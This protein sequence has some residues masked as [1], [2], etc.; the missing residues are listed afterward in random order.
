MKKIRK[1]IQDGKCGKAINIP[2]AFLKHLPQDTKSI[3]FKG[4]INESIELRTRTNGTKY[5]Y[6]LQHIDI[7]IGETILS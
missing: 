1:I 7:N 3:T 2:V 6:L 4:V 5:C